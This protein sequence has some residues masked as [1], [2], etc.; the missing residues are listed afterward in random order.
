MEPQVEGHVVPDDGVAT[1]TLNNPAKRNAIGPRM[2]NEL[3][4]ALD[5]AMADGEVR[6]VVITGAGK[7]FCAGGDFSQM[8]GGGDASELPPKGDY[9]DLLFE[10]RRSG[11]FFPHLGHCALGVPHSEMKIPCPRGVTSCG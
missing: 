5:G 3:L 11:G 2:V 9:A 8:S 10:Y 4:Y 6:S 1:I 7:A